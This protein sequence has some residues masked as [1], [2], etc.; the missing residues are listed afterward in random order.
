MEQLGNAT[1]IYVCSA[2]GCPDIEIAK[3][4]LNIPAKERKARCPNCKWEGTLAECAGIATTEKVFNTKTVL[5]L[6]IFVVT[7]HAAGP[8]AQVLQYIGLVEKDDQEGLNKVMREATAGLVERA[9]LAAAEHAA[10]KQMNKPKEPTNE[11]RIASTFRAALPNRKP[12]SEETVANVKAY[13]TSETI[14]QAPICIPVAE[15]YQF[16]TGDMMVTT[17]HGAAVVGGELEAHNR[18]VNALA[19]EFGKPEVE[20]V[21]EETT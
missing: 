9:L 13:L 16:D 1:T 5:D 14:K 15:I 18:M 6:L 7:K 19:A 20:P 11:E 2:C 8:V 4:E 12:F 17:L 21:A 3:S 10:E